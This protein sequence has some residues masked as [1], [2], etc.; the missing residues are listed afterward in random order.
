MLLADHPDRKPSDLAYVRVEQ[1][2]DYCVVLYCTQAQCSEWPNNK[3]ATTKPSVVQKLPRF[4]F[5][6]VLRIPIRIR[7]E[8]ASYIRIRIPN[9]DPHMQI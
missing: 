7:I 1:S 8:E 3:F 5:N 2:V 4:W 6:S 9:T